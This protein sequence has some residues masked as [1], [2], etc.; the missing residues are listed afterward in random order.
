M[1]EDLWDE[2]P[3]DFY[4]A[5]GRS[6]QEAITS[7]QCFLEGCDNHDSKKLHP[8][9]KEYMKS[10]PLDDGSYFEYTRVKM[11]CDVCNGVF[12]FGLK[13]IYPPKSVVGK[14]SIMG[15]AYIYDEK[16]KDLGFI[17]YF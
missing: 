3:S 1:Q 15:T 17:G 4:I 2:I 8:L 7:E 16:G 14:G 5:L 12:H 9:E 13:L 11:K 10:E 6:G